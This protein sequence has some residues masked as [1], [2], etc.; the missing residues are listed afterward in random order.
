MSIGARHDRN[1]HDLSRLVR[2]LDMSLDAHEE[3]LLARLARCSVWAGRYPV[4]AGPD[5]MRN[6][7]EFSDGRNY[8]LAYFAA[9][10]LQRVH[11]LLERNENRNHLVPAERFN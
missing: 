4:P 7:Q 11:D 3:E 2:R 8:L 9:P 5:G 10:D 1:D 6:I